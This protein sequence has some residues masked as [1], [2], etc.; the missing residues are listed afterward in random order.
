MAFNCRSPKGR[1]I[2]CDQIDTR[3]KMY[4]KG[5]LALGIKN[6]GSPHWGS[7]YVV[8]ILQ[9]PNYAFWSILKGW[10]RP[11]QYFNETDP[12]ITYNQEIQQ[13]VKS[14]F[15]QQK[16]RFFFVMKTMV[17]GYT[18]EWK[19]HFKIMNGLVLREGASNQ[20]SENYVVVRYFGKSEQTE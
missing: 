12:R 17:I 15:L 9:P 16:Y 10:I 11:T 20:H 19:I 6:L 18:C 3:P 2:N 4:K 13:F 14:H 8:T 5:F 1:S 7:L